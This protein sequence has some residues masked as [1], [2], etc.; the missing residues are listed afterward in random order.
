MRQA[1]LFLVKSTPLVEHMSYALKSE[2]LRPVSKPRKE[3]ENIV[4]RIISEILVVIIF[5]LSMLVNLTRFFS[6]GNANGVWLQMIFRM[7]VYSVLPLLPLTFP[8]IWGYF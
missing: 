7:P 6:S 1:R 4:G 3:L 2:S 8:V 5:V